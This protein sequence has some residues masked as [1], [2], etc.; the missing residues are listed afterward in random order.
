MARIEKSQNKLKFY[1][2]NDEQVAIQFIKGGAKSE[3]LF[4]KAW[5]IL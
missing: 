3:F 4:E 2:L 5:L 1:T